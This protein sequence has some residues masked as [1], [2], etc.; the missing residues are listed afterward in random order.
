MSNYFA[1]G[2]LLSFSPSPFF[3]LCL[4]GKYVVTKY[5][6]FFSVVVPGAFFSQGFVMD[7]LCAQFNFLVDSTFLSDTT[8]QAH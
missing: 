6:A 2:H 7:T 5:P 3:P 4:H 8:P 1:A